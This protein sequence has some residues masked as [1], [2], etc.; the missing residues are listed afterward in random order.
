MTNLSK[1]RSGDIS[2]AD[3]QWSPELGLLNA[4]HLRTEDRTAKEEV[5]QFFREDVEDLRI[6][7]GVKLSGKSVSTIIAHRTMVLWLPHI[8]VADENRSWA[9]TKACSLVLLDQELTVERT[10]LIGHRTANNESGRP[11][12]A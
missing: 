11:S 10:A 6:L 12:D 8:R 9:H 5:L 7:C 2:K 4:T 1:P 3:A